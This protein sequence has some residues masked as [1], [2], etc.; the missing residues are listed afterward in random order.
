MSLQRL[1]EGITIAM[2]HT[3]RVRIADFAGAPGEGW[4]HLE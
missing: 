2:V 4:G 3:D 1:D